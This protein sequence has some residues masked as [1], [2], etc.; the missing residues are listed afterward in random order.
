MLVVSFLFCPHGS[1]P[2]TGWPPSRQS[3][4]VG[5]VTLRY[6]GCRSNGLSH[7][8]RTGRRSCGHPQRCRGFHAGKQAGA[9]ASRTC[10][11][12]WLLRG[13][14]ASEEEKDACPQLPQV[15]V[16]WKLVVESASHSDAGL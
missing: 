2:L 11:G 15:A 16:A 13:C 8:Y 14:A 6:D 3:F 12:S 10:Q 7:G 4:V 5:Q 9:D 1:E